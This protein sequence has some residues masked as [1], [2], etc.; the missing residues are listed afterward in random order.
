MV[1]FPSLGA[2]AFPSNGMQVLRGRDER[3]DVQKGLD[4]SYHSLEV[5]KFKD[6]FSD[7]PWPLFPLQYSFPQPSNC[8]VSLFRST[9]NF[10]PTP[11]VGRRRN[12]SAY[13][14]GRITSLLLTRV[15]GWAV[16]RSQGLIAGV[17]FPILPNSNSARSLTF[18][19]DP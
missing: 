3:R 18:L 13:P 2:A 14:P 8:A 4:H 5:S 11:G 19:L 7:F 15:K 1:F 10:T 9:I 17:E 6:I 16:G 12:A